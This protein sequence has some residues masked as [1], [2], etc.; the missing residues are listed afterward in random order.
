MTPTHE[1]ELASKLCNTRK[2][3]THINLLLNR[4]TEAEMSG[5]NDHAR[6]LLEEAFLILKEKLETLESKLEREQ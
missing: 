2:T 6:L 1:D 4:A 5:L 3:N